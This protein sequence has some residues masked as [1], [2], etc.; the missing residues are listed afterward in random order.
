MGTVVE[1]LENHAWPESSREKWV[2]A[3]DLAALLV[4]APL[5]LVPEEV[6][7]AGTSLS[8]GRTRAESLVLC[9]FLG[10]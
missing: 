10:Q 4:S 2:S 1:K 9:P 7:A 5:F 6:M 3:A 8:A